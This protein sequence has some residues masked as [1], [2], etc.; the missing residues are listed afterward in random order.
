VADPTEE[1]ITTVIDAGRRA[2]QEALRKFGADDRRN[3]SRHVAVEIITAL[4][5]HWAEKAP[6]ASTL[7]AEATR[8]FKGGQGE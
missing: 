7:W 3:V 8:N 2:Q 5:A 1:E 4:D 6:D